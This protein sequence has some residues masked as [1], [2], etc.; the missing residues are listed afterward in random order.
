MRTK[1]RMRSVSIQAKT[2]EEF[3]RRFTEA[4]REIS[5]DDPQITVD[6]REEFRASIIYWTTEE[7]RDSV[8]DEF[9]EEGFRF[10]CRQCPLREPT[11]D[12]RKKYIRCIYS[13][14]GQTHLE[15]EA[16]EIFY[17]GVKRGDIE[18]TDERPPKTRRK[19]T[20]S[21]REELERTGGLEWE[22]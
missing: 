20:R 5:E 13:E 12:K 14:L 9:H 22:D 16:C 4:T 3:D 2:A 11:G 1:R 19:L 18:P 6:L 17:R 8:A 21:E 15:H 10:T 7:I